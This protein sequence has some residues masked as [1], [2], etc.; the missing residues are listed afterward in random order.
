MF[1]LSYILAA[2]GESERQLVST[3]IGFPWKSPSRGFLRRLLASIRIG[4]FSSLKFPSRIRLLVRRFGVQPC[5]LPLFKHAIKLRFQ[6]LVKSPNLVSEFYIL[7]LHKGLE[8]LEIEH[9]ASRG[10]NK[11]RG[12]MQV[13]E[14]VYLIITIQLKRLCE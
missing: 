1:S 14:T 12:D 4:R 7:L 6:A 8:S 10:S 5:A 2:K 9:C 3:S 13:S 11:N